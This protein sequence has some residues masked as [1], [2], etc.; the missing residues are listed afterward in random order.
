M[1]LFL[2]LSVKGT[3]NQY[4]FNIQCFKH[5]G[6]SENVT[7]LLQ[8]PIRIALS[9][10]TI[11]DCVSAIIK[12]YKISQDLS[13]KKIS[14]SLFL[15]FSHDSITKFGMGLLDIFIQGTDINTMEP[16]IAP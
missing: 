6:E 9:K 2:T 3:E 14:N 11:Y 15:D 12:A 8:P 7:S 4:L 13:Y 5:G 1:K 10:D 16:I